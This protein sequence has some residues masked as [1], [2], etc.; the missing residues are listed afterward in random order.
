M[1]SFGAPPAIPIW[2]KVSPGFSLHQ[3]AKAEQDGTDACIERQPT[4]LAQTSTLESTEVASRG[5]QALL[6]LWQGLLAEV[7]SKDAQLRLGPW[8]G[9]HKSRE[10]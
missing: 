2:P 4:S 5:A 6:G 8:Q 1:Q 3:S 9:L 7:A 10:F